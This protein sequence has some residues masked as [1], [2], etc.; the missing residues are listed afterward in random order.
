MHKKITHIA[1]HIYEGSICLVHNNAERMYFIRRNQ[2]Y[3]L[4][5]L[6]EAIE[7]PKVFYIL[8]RARKIHPPECI[9][10][11]DK[12]RVEER[13]CDCCRYNHICK[14]EEL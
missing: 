6:R 1:E 8:K 4:K 2:S 12:G 11:F 5:T 13:A 10:T 14:E 3:K 7:D 9:H